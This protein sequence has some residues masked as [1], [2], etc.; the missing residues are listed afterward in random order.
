MI[1]SE[2]AP[3]PLPAPE[4]VA[5][6]VGRITVPLPFPVPSHIHCYVLLDD[7][8][9]VDAGMRGSMDALRA[10]LDH[11]GVAV[12]CVVLTH[13][14]PDHWALAGAVCERALAHPRGFH[15]FRVHPNL[16]ASLGRSLP[17]RAVTSAEMAELMAWT[18]L[19]E[20]PPMI[21][22]II[23]GAMIGEWEVVDTPGHAPGHICLFRRRDGVLIAGD[24]LL[25]KVLPSLYVCDQAP[26]PVGDVLSSL[27]RVSTLDLRLV[28]PSHGKPFTDVQPRIEALSGYHTGVLAAL[29][30]LLAEAP[31]AT[32]C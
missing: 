26:D 20:P 1:A 7:G 16:S 9:L 30:R 5:P 11:F 3:R 13:G 32:P 14:H 15:E 4:L 21:E 29:R 31:A 27:D 24:Q 19:T 17:G 6:G 28:L 23:G 8:V 10:G 2:G 18:A 12:E 25:A 22:P